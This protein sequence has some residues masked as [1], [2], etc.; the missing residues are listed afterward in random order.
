MYCVAGCSAN[1]GML[2]EL[3]KTYDTRILVSEKTF[4]HAAVQEKVLCRL[5]DYACAEEDDGEMSVL[6]VTG[7]R[8]PL[9]FWYEPFFCWDSFCLFPFELMP[10]HYVREDD[11]AF[12]I[13]GNR[14]RMTRM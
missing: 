14:K 12:V 2:E 6:S 9:C 8:V 1:A 4:G 10:T 3:N 7:Y 11:H 13:V 5:I